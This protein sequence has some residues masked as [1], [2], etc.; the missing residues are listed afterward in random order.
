[1]SFIF[2]LLNMIIW[3]VW[4]RGFGLDKKLNPLRRSQWV[5]LMFVLLLPF[6]FIGWIHYIVACSISAILWTFGHNFD[7]WAVVFRYPV[8]GLW[9]P[10]LKRLWN[11]KWN[12]KYF[13]GY[14]AVAEFMMGASYGVVITLLYTNY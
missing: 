14:S 12:T 1:M 3:G 11:D 5:A 8:I 10:I 9:Y 4:R 2:C 6:S 13:D 7:K